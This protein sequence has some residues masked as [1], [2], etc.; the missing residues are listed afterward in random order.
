MLLLL[1]AIT[2]LQTIYIN[3]VWSYHNQ[4]FTAGYYN[5]NFWHYHPYIL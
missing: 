1:H 2:E 3:C 4:L 5:L